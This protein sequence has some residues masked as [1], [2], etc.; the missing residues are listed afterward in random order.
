VLF[1][2]SQP[3]LAAVWRAIHN[4]QEKQKMTQ[5]DV[6]AITTQ[7][8]QVAQDL[9]AAQVKL[10]AEIDALAAA[11]PTVDLTALQAAVA[12]LD[13][14]VLALGG[15]TPDVPPAPTPPPAP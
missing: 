10:Q 9:T 15:L 11:N 7:V 4:I 3:D 12:P 6:D 13:A 5:S 2:R 1:G 8:D 14:A